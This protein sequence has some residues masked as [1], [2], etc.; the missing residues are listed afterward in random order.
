MRELW[1]RT[2]SRKPTKRE[3]LGILLLRAG[4]SQLTS[5]KRLIVV[6]SLFTVSNVVYSVKT[7][8]QDIFGV[9]QTKES[10]ETTEQLTSRQLEEVSSCTH[11]T[12][13]LL[14]AGVSVCLCAMC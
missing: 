12:L 7:N 6:L 1:R 4:H 11:C 13:L 9:D 14:L 5:S 3:P 8:L 2:Y 10:D